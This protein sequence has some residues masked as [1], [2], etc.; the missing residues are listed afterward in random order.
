MVAHGYD[1]ATRESP[2]LIFSNLFWGYLVRLIT[3][4]NGVLG[5]SIAMLSVLIAVGTAVIFGLC[6]LVSAM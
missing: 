2:N 6:G 5:Y 4:I 1:V 3:E